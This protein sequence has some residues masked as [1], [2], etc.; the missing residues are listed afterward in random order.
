MG[1]SKKNN[2]LKKQVKKR[3][4][5]MDDKII[6]GTDAILT[7]SIDTGK[8]WTKFIKKA[9]TVTKPVR[10]KQIDVFFDTTEAV[11]DQLE[12]GAE[13]MKN[14]LG[15]EEPIGEIIKKEL[16]KNK[17][18]KTINNNVNKLVSIVVPD[19]VKKRV[20]QGA[21]KIKMEI[22]NRNPFKE[23]T[24]KAPK[25]LTRKKKASAKKKAMKKV[26][27]KPK[28]IAKKTTAKARSTGKKVTTQPKSIIKKVASKPRTSVKRSSAKETIKRKTIVAH[29]VSKSSSKDNLT[30]ITGIGPKMQ[31]LLNKKGISTFKELKAVPLRELQ[32]IID[33]AG[34]AFSKYKAKDWRAQAILAIKGNM[35]K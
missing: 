12:K 4:E 14:K 1:K 16:E 31:Q 13:V 35:S 5:D 28:V 18:A 8:K 33:G 22:E 20:Q 23:E 17:V 29:K 2:Q 25:K 15:I 32:S 27:V 6:D 9:I 24:P 34:S 11:R 21:V 3:L 7:I 26:V 10:E 30:K 19:A